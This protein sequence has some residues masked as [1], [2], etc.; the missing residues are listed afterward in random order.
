MGQDKS[1]LDFREPDEPAP[2][3]A[4]PPSGDEAVPEAPA[5][6][7]VDVEKAPAGKLLT[8]ERL[9]R[10]QESAK[11][12]FTSCK[13]ALNAYHIAIRSIEGPQEGQEMED[14][15]DGDEDEEAT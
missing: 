1:L 15:D 2:E 12:S 5:D 4:E 8:K 11:D 7:V 6:L 3:G 9:Q 14:E 10:I 13:A